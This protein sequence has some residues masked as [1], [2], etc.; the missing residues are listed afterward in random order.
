[1]QIAD[2]GQLIEVDNGFVMGDEPVEDEIG[3]DE[4]GTACD[5]NGHKFLCNAACV[6]D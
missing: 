5:K 4:T 2:I 6:Q 3:A 1:M